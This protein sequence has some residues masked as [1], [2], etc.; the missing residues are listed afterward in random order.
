[1]EEQIQQWFE[2]HED[3]YLEFDD[4]ETKFSKRA[5]LHAFILLDKLLPESDRNIISA[6]EHDEFFLEPGL[7]ELAEAKIT[8]AQ[9]IDLLRCGVSLD[10][11]TESLRMFA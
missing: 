4:I 11:D 7:S 1:M 5:D 8:E 6:A 2:T 10:L 3:E 9:V